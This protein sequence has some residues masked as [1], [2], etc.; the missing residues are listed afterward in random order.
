M[1]FV[2]SLKIRPIYENEREKDVNAE[3]VFRTSWSIDADIETNR[4]IDKYF[5]LPDGRV[6]LQES[7]DINVK[8]NSLPID[9]ESIEITA[10]AMDNIKPQSVVVLYNGVKTENFS[11][12][13]ATGILNIS[14]V[15]EKNANNEII[16]GS[17]SEEYK[18][19]Y[20]YTSNVADS[21]NL[22]GNGSNNAFLTD[23]NRVIELNSKIDLGTE[24][25]II[26]PK[27]SYINFE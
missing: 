4:T 17:G 11:Y 9:S 14:R 24:V 12:D 5:S 18:I 26:F 10:P 27:N 15:N 16:W 22:E 1:V 19:I 13:T 8:D 2:S 25:R 21:S 20:L 6:L 23:G 3:I 7:L